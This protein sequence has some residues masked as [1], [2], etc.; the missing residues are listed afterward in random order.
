M[1]SWDLSDPGHPVRTIVARTL[2]DGERIEPLADRIVTID[3]GF[4]VSVRAFSGT[5]LA[6]EDAI[7][8]DILAPG[9]IDMQIN[10]AADAQF[11]EQP[12]IE[13]L[14]RMS[15]GARQGGTAHIL[16]T[17][18]TAPGMEYRAA[19]DATNAAI[20]S[21]VPG[22]LGVHLEG[23]FLSKEKPGI[24]SS[25]CIRSLTQED[26]NALRLAKGIVLV[27]LAPE[28]QDLGY[29]RE[30]AGAGIHVFA[31]H[32]NAT[33]GQMRSGIAAG[34]KGVTHLFNA[35]SQISA[36][37][38]GVAGSALMNGH[39]FAGIIADGFHVDPQNLAMAAHLMGNRLCLVTDSMKTINGTVTSFDLCG[40]SIVL[41]NG[42]LTGPEG[43]LAGAHLSMDQ[44]VRNAMT[45]MGCPP[46][47]ALKMAST[48]P[49]RALALDGQLGK[50]KQ[51]YRASLT[52]LSADFRPVGT[53][54][55]GRLFTSSAM[56]NRSL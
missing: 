38:P 35:Q 1:R 55:D 23:P 40:T 22:I 18:I 49:A 25:A 14:M 20:A 37:E 32:S 51:C 52:C 53:V 21:G 10:G 39:L 30:L 17:F 16:P 47:T 42:K 13:T 36:R 8:V 33:A 34:V 48:N 5:R 15:A 24:H 9:F 46:A 56:T 12:T 41:E 7:T 27:T 26:I 11:N 45:M 44:A 43:T 54:V 50:I 6:A 31:G 4:I 2:Y 28:V 3:N 29:V 19:I